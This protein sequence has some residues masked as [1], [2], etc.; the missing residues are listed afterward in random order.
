MSKCEQRITGGC[1]ALLACGD[2]IRLQNLLGFDQ[3]ERLARRKARVKTRK[4]IQFDYFFK[5]CRNRAETMEAMWCRSSN[6]KWIQSSKKERM[7]PNPAHAQTV[8]QHRED[9]QRVHQPIDS[10]FNCPAT[11]KRN[12]LQQ[13]G[14]ECRVDSPRHH[15]TFVAQVPT[16]H[17]QTHAF[18]SRGYVPP[19]Y[20]H[21]T[22]CAF[23]AVRVSLSLTSIPCLLCV[24]TPA[25]GWMGCRIGCWFLLLFSAQLKPVATRSRLVRLLG[26]IL[27]F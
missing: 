7:C 13:N 25:V 26:I 21:P 15:P 27:P 12:V 4:W 23:G 20:A 22:V 16:S 19:S 17:T 6:E 18:K 5:V 14:N 24:S 2:K 8:H 11:R 9:E 10:I 1:L 3:T